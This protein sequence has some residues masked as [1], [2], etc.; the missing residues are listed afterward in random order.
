MTADRGRPRGQAARAQAVQKGKR[1]TAHRV[2]KALA[3]VAACVCAGSAVTVYGQDDAEMTFSV[4]GGPEADP[5]S[6][7]AVQPPPPDAPPSEGLAKGMRL[8]RQRKY[9][10][11]SMALQPIADGEVEDAPVNAQKAQFLLAKSLF[12]MGFYQTSLTIFDE[13]SALSTGHVHYADTLQ[14]LAQLTQKLPD[15]AGLSDKVGRYDVNMIMDLESKDKDKNLYANLLLL[16]AKDRYAKG[17]FEQAVELADK[18][19]KDSSSYIEAQFFE[20]VSYVRMRQAK[21]AIA[22]FRGIIEAIDDGD[23]KGVSDEDRMQNL[24]WIT[25]GRIYYTAANRTDAKSGDVVIDGRL[26]GNA[27][28]A[29]SRVDVSSEYWLDALFEGSWAFFLA[30][31]YSRAL[32]N[33]HSLYSP[34]FPDAYYPEALVIKAVTFFVNCQIDNAR[35]VVADF[36]T[37]YDP[38]QRGLQEELKKVEDNTAFFEFLRRVQNGEDTLS[39]SIRAV[40]ASALSDRQLLANV[41]YVRV[42]EEE[43]ERFN[44]S[45]QRFKESGVG[46]RVLQDI[47]IAKAFAI[48]QTGDL[49]R[50]RYAR[51]TRE[52]QQLMNQ[53]DT[54]ELEIA[55]FERGQLSQE[56]QEQQTA[57][58]RSK[59]GNV[60]VDEEHQIWPF[61][62][63][64]WR[65]ELGFYRQ[66]VTNVCGR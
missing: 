9:A 33:I 37:R 13:I 57:A 4:E 24:A 17:E 14:W 31:E 60:V 59:G 18:I 43:E 62:G 64:Y 23:T 26:L 30:D 15:A 1:A 29:W 11:A 48:D 22:A 3:G 66:Q 63:E 7:E 41:E 45:S 47:A 54:I 25:L 10:E 42:L 65:D 44:K 55:T 50:A 56:A 20:G 58:A 28:E 32:G 53:V 51:L 27:T 35:A 52:L 46:S 6:A 19:P 61:D 5:S 2:P 39:P 8:Y 40:V 12:Y 49:A 34:F 16:L 21:P 36:H 38:V